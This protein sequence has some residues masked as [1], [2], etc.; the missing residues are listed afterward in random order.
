V[1]TGPIL[2][3]DIAARAGIGWFGKHTSLLS[4]KLGNWFFLGEI[5]LNIELD[6]DTPATAHCGTCKRCIDACPTGAIVSPY[7]LDARLCISYLTIELK[8]PMPPE[9]RPLIGNRIF[10]CDDCLAVCPWNKHARAASEI[11]FQPGPGLLMPDLRE[12]MRLTEEEFRVRF[13][14]SPIKRIKRRGLLRNV[15]VALGNAKDCGSVPVLMDALKDLEPLI[16]AHAAWALG[17]IGSMEAITALRNTIDEECDPSVRKEIEDA[18]AVNHGSA[19]A[20]P[21]GGQQHK[22]ID[23]AE[24]TTCQE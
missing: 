12:L 1:D 15:A 10:G 16:R 18:L 5:L 6:Y 21:D 20:S 2:E 3:R 4:K 19:G 7:R 11:R 22:S 17:Q 14:N 9:M 8:G 13:Q 24:K 23:V